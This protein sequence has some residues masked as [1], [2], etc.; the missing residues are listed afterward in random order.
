MKHATSAALDTLSDLLQQIRLKE[1]LREKGPGVFYR[2]SKAFLHFH[3]DPAG[4]FADIRA[5]EDFDRYPVNT[6]AQQRALL[7]AIDRAL[8][9]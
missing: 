9:G 2:K 4:M 5:G 3:E 7:A 1:G 6:R 8:K